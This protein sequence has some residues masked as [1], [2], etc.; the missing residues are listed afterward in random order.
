MAIHDIE[1]VI[2]QPCPQ[3]ADIPRLSKQF[4][5]PSHKDLRRRV[6]EGLVLEQARHAVGVGDRP[7]D[8]GVEALVEGVE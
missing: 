3:I 8:G 2:L 7:P 4:I 6:D 5:E 1:R